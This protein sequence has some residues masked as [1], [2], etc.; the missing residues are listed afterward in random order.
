MRFRHVDKKR[1]FLV[2]LAVVVM[3][4]CLTFLNQVNMGTDPCTVFNLGVSGKL[5][6]SLGNWQALLNTLLLVVIYFSGREM[7]GWGTLANM[8]LVGYSYDFFSFLNRKWMWEGMFDSL[9]VRSLVVIPTLLVFIFAVAIY[10][11]CDLGTSPYD[12]IPIILAKKSA[13]LP[14][15]A[16]RIIYDIVFATVGFLLGS[17]VGVVTLVMAFALGP[18]ITWVRVHVIEKL[19]RVL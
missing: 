7:I 5:G 15:K 14:F 3:G 19:L 12:A 17:K 2:V 6:M 1:L 13:R 10:I 16:I 11:A 8:F 9:L 18:V 4:F